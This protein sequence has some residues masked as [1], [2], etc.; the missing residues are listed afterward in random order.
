M[1]STHSL[2]S[3]KPAKS[4][5]LFRVVQACDECRRR[6]IRC[7]GLSGG[8]EHCS[9]AGL[10]CRT[11]K[12]LTRRASS[13]LNTNLSKGPERI[14]VS[15]ES[16]EESTF[17]VDAVSFSRNKAGTSTQH[18][19]TPATETDVGISG[20]EAEVNPEPLPHISKVAKGWL[21][22]ISDNHIAL[23]EYSLCLML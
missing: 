17:K 12:K 23:G 1:P 10:E 7:E 4:K 3:Q 14:W 11:S 2:R 8:C 22:N 9:H 18:G 19:T 21:G 20:Y 5:Q 13:H 15:K 16:L 6:K